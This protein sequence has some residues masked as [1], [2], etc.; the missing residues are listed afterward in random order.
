MTAPIYSTCL[1]LLDDYRRGPAAAARGGARLLCF[2]GVDGHD[3]YN[4]TAPLEWD[5]RP[6]LFG[7]REARDSEHSHLVL[8]GCDD[9]ECWRPSMDWAP[10]ESLQ[11]PCF[12]FL[13]GDLVLGGVRFP[14]PM[15][16]GTLGW[17]M[18]FYRLR[19]GDRAPELLFSGP[20]RMKDIR[21]RQLPDR[22]IAAFTRPQGRVGGRGRIGFAVA[23]DLAEI[24]AEFLQSAPLF[25]DQ[26]PDDEWSGANEIHLLSDGSLGVLGH[27]AMFDAQD[28]RHY[29]AMAFTVDPVTAT[30]GP[31]RIIAERRDF[32][33]GP[34][35]RPDLNNVIF[36]GGLVRGAGRRAMLYA[37]LSDAAAACI[38]I[39]DPFAEGEETAAAEEEVETITVVL[40]GGGEE[41]LVAVSS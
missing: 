38:T 33:A 9:T 5:G 12:T 31:L 3:V 32:P 13:D 16:D 15:R 23:E 34:S 27:I 14:V 37:G 40:A 11:D 24:D 20:D 39:G 29:F 26:H 19:P 21:L 28:H 25:P 2:E 17:R 10:M 36:S 35:K 18:E 22:R 8:F 6:H 30:A 1:E 4:V 41:D 7:R